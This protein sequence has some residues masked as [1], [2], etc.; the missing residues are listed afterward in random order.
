MFC[1][2]C[3]TWLSTGLLPTQWHTHAHFLVVGAKEKHLN[4]LRMK[5]FGGSLPFDDFYPAREAVNTVFT[6]GRADE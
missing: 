1:L 6:D 2:V 5:D 4:R 3:Y